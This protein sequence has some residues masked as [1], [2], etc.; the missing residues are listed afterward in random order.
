MHSE[1]TAPRSSAK[2]EP[3]YFE[4]RLVKGGPLVGARIVCDNGLW[5]AW[6]DGL[7]C[8]PPHPDPVYATGV[9]RIWYS[10]TRSDEGT[11]LFRLDLREWALRHDPEHWAARPYQPIALDVRPPLF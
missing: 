6:I 2:P 4:L 10:G 8:G 5:S 7:L 11:Y 1:W 9:Y 3:G